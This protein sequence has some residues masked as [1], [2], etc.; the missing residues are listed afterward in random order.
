MPNK[1][2]PQLPPLGRAP[3]A[4][5]LVPVWDG[6][7]SR[8]TY[9][10]VAELPGTGGGGG[11]GGGGG[12]FTQLA[13]PFMVF[14]GSPNYVYDAVHNTV[15]ISDVRLLNKTQYPVASTQY[16]GEFNMDKLS[17]YSVDPA[18]NTK[19]KVVISDFKLDDNAH[20]TITIPGERD[21]SGDSNYAQ[22]VADVALLKLIAAPF[23]ATALGPNGGKVFW[24]MAA[25]LIP[26]GWQEYQAMRGKLPIAQDP[27]DP[28]NAVTNPD[29]LSRAIGSTGGAKS[30]K[31]V[32]ANI[33]EL[34]YLRP[35]KI[36]DVDR[37]TLSS[38][39]S[40]DDIET[41]KVGT[42]DAQMKNVN[43]MN[44]YRIVTWI[45]FVGVD[46]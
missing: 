5:D 19:G 9:A 44:P 32:A 43:V 27:T 13:T 21:S 29:G 3:K 14:P 45:E 12:T 22:L 8:T 23:F 28:Y 20:I 39:W 46:V 18:D 15:T 33:P 7:T 42:P 38:S 35:K 37:G 17:Y 4:G 2:I 6:D 31:L 10:D 11:G 16:G 1:R 25:N 24:G 34:D 40:L 41:G 36:P 30:V 26:A